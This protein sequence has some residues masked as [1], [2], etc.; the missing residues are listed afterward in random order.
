MIE[1]LNPTESKSSVF[2]MI[3]FGFR[4]FTTDYQIELKLGSVI[5]ENFIDYRIELKLDKVIPENFCRTLI[6]SLPYVVLTYSV[7]SLLRTLGGL[8][9]AVLIRELS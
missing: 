8:G 5:P 7:T 9:L 6:P 2:D 4:Q 1:H 3:W